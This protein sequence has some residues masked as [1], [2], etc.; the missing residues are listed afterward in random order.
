MAGAVDTPTDEVLLH[1]YAHSGNRDAFRSLMERRWAEAY[2]LSLRVLADPQA[3]EDAAQEAFVAV[4]RNAR[5]FKAGRAF[6]PWFR[7]LVVNAARMSSRSRRTRHRYED[8]YAER[9][10]GEVVLPEGE[11][12]LAEEE[13]TEHLRELPFKVRFPL[14]LHFFEGCTFEEVAAVVGC[15]KPT[16]QT[17]IRAGL[18]LL[19]A[20]LAGAGCAYSIADID[21][22]FARARAGNR[23]V[24]V[25]SMPS[26][27]LVEGAAKKAAL[28]AGAVKLVAGVAL[29]A[30]TSATVVG[31]VA[32][33]NGRAN[34][35]VANA[36]VNPGG[37]APAKQERPV[38]Q[39]APADA[40]SPPVNCNGP[41][42]KNGAPA[43]PPKAAPEKP[44]TGPLRLKI[45]LQAAPG[46][47]AQGVRTVLR[48]DMTDEDTKKAVADATVR[49]AVPPQEMWRLRSQH[50]VA[51]IAVLEAKTDHGGHFELQIPE[52]AKGK[53]ASIDVF[54]RGFLSGAIAVFGADPHD[55]SIE[56]GEASEV[57]LELP[58]A[59]YVAGQVVDEKS[60]PVA[61]VEVTAYSQRKRGGRSCVTVTATDAD[62]RFEIYDFE[63]YD[64][65]VK[66]PGYKGQY[67]GEIE[68]KHPKFRRATIDDVYALTE[69]DRG[70]QKIVLNRGHI[71]SGRVV[72][73]AGNFVAGVMVE[74][75]FK[76]YTQRRAVITDQAGCF[77]LE[78]LPSDGE[79][80]LLVH[81]KK[82]KEK[83]RRKLEMSG[84]PVFEITLEPIVLKTEP[85]V[86]QLLGMKLANVTEE[87]RDAYDL[88]EASGVLI[89]DPGI[90]HARLGIGALEEGYRFWDV[91]DA[92]IK[93]IAEMAR[94]ILKEV[95]A[96][97]D[98][99]VRVVFDFAEVGFAGTRT[100]SLKLTEADLDEL[101]KFVAQT[102]D[103][104]AR[105]TERRY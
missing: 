14:V 21:G 22:W 101:R 66:S 82:L 19:R 100:S 78:G 58:R 23:A 9:K 95:E 43:P 81:D 86:V 1:D 35:P 48:G 75:R 63:I 44:S 38:N 88:Y 94:E 6:G 59:L 8:R 36:A 74:A 91:G 84:D 55:V 28:L 70:A 93:T 30:I 90:A 20:S 40:P 10:A 29:L 15:P 24:R 45:V 33:G 79:C 5:Q 80:T 16:V 7:T 25:P 103:S 98:H 105:S 26:V 37:N 18:D 39:G 11:R 4:V 65:D 64:F 71:V 77:T 34:G 27:A 3:A 73:S 47:A 102:P 51:G 72:S 2:R 96:G 46:V 57:S 61:G 13:V 99:G 69:A 97:P 104:R 42:D 53:K 12:R 85:E 89:L 56:P 54:V 60:A 68:F 67:R 92:K 49:V 52:S 62:G 76:D 31:L 17:R 50:D 41:D 87:L 83:S 32:H